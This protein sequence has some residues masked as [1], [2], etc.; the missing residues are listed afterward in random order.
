MYTAILYIYKNGTFT[1]KK[2]YFNFIQHYLLNMNFS[3]FVNILINILIKPIETQ[4][5]SVNFNQ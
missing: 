2:T 5:K 4:E 1:K 3:N